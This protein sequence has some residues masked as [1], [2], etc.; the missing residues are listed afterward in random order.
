VEDYSCE[1]EGAVV[2]PIFD[3]LD[4]NK[5]STRAKYHCK[6][7]LLNA[8]FEAVR[9]HYHDESDKAMKRFVDDF[10]RSVIMTELSDRYKIREKAYGFKVI[11]ARLS[12][13]LLEPE[14]DE[15]KQLFRSLELVKPKPC[16]AKKKLVWNTIVIYLEKVHT[17]TSLAKG[18]EAQFCKSIHVAMSIGFKA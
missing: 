14:K 2:G 13:E 4:F 7:E 16:D 17:L 18:E 5:K 12:D 10:Q 11:L 9:E 6:K 8:V 3:M 1:S 15:T